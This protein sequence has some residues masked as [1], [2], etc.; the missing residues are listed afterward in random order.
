[1]Q[2]L[3]YF[4]TMAVVWGVANVS[5]GQIPPQFE[6]HHLFAS[7]GVGGDTYGSSVSISGDV[8]IV[9]VPA[10]DT[11]VGSW[12]GSAFVYRLSGSSWIEEA[13]LFAPNGAAFDTFGYSVSVSGNV[14]VV[15]APRDDVLGLDAGSAYVYL[16]DGTDWILNTQLFASD[17][18]GGSTPLRGDRFGWSVSASTNVVIIGASGDNTSSGVDAGSA[19]V[20]RK[21]GI[22][23]VEEAH[24]FASGGS[25]SEYYGRAVSISGNTAIIGAQGDDGGGTT[26]ASAYIYR[27]DGATWNEEAHLMANNGASFD[28]FGSSVSIN[29]DVAIV[30]AAQPDAPGNP[31]GSAFIYRFNGSS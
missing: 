20:F 1:M 24:L 2:M 10:D 29:G 27:F 5:D 28:N 11:A 12:V 31:S 4:L 13:H 22:N 3:N 26:P 16:F 14:A 9:G 23:W 25:A 17:G 8:A 6:D 30:G 19:Y 7:D 18:E 21:N 15:G